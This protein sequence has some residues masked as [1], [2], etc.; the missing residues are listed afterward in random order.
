[1]DDSFWIHC[2][3]NTHK[4]FRFLLERLFLHFIF[5]PSSL[6]PRVSFSFFLHQT[7]S[8]F[9]R[10]GRSSIEVSTNQKKYT[11]CFSNAF[12]Y[13]W[14]YKIVCCLVRQNRV[15]STQNGALFNMDVFMRCYQIPDYIIWCTETVLHNT[16][17]LSSL[18]ICSSTPDFSPNNIYDR[19]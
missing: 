7:N 10:V 6:S 5:R 12:I 17:L 16:H 11:S 14:V 15:Y 1:M 13:T 9:L 8:Y 19:F 18:V 2:R 3:F 4:L